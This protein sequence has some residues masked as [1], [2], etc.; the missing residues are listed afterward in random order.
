M[1]QTQSPTPEA[2]LFE[3]TQ[4]W[5]D[6]YSATIIK[7][8]IITFLLLTVLILL[9]T[10]G[11]L[12]EI[13]ENWPKYR[14]NPAL[15]PFASNFGY[16][17]KENFDFC[18]NSIFRVKASEI[19]VPIYALLANFTGIVTL[20]TDVALGIRK[21]FSNF[22]FTMNSFVRNVRDRIQN[23]L[24][25]IRISF[26]RINVLMGRVYGSMFAVIWTGISALTATQSLPENG[27]VKF[28]IGF[29]FHPNTPVHMR[30]GEKKAIQDLKIGD[31]LTEGRVTSLFRF[32]GS[33]T[34]MVQIKDVILS[35]NHIVQCPNGTWKQAEEHP[36]A[37]PVNSIPEIYCLNVEGHRC[38]VGESLHVADYDE[39]EHEMVVAIAQQLAEAG[40]NGGLSGPSVSDY[41][42]GFDPEVEIRVSETE[43][44]PVQ[45]LHLG[46]TLYGNQI[47]LG[48]VQEECSS[49]CTLHGDI[50]VS[51]AQLVYTGSAWKRAETVVQTKK[52]ETRV[53]S[54]VITDRV[55]PLCIR[56]GTIVYWL[57]DYREAPLPEMEDVY[58][59]EVCNSL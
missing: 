8:V 47:V 28:I 35:A 57:R 4:K 55:G 37:I 34:P 10:L 18:L 44:K 16:D 26:H 32:D 46:D 58:Q 38:T 15:M 6:N 5:K 49:I 50:D 19:F 25:R 14:C 36:Y 43:W 31:T 9:F 53:L 42:L 54:Q 12:R 1:S 51:A 41:S 30:N 20:V 27:L 45:S 13:A 11:N 2:L 22:L 29:C 33:K 17:V 56:K 52:Q 7:V 23:L 21:L 40:L 39:S 24:F 48:L 3:A 59:S